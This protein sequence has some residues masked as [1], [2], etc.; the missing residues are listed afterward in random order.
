[1]AAWQHGGPAHRPFC[2]WR[3]KRPHTSKCLTS[4]SSP[5]KPLEIQPREK[6]ASP[7]P[8][9]SRRHLGLVF[10]HRAL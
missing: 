5:G 7:G 8:G 6:G 4:R 9:H 3:E 1:M 2:L 10:T